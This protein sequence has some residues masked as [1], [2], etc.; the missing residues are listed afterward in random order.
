MESI[1][2]D[3]ISIKISGIK[4]LISIWNTRKLTPY[5]NVVIIKSLLGHCNLLTCLTSFSPISFGEINH[6]SSINR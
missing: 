3:N 6:I 2:D 5:G 4:K 1:T